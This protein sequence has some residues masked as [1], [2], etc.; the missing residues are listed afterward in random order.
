M[1]TT[2]AVKYSFNASFRKVMVEP[3]RTTKSR[4]KS[5]PSAPSNTR[6]GVEE[7]DL[8]Q[9][10]SL[11]ADKK[12]VRLLEI[13][14]GRELEPI[15][16]ELG[17]YDLDE[18]PEYIALSYMWDQG[19]G[20][21][22]IECQGSKIEVTENLWQFLRQYRARMMEKQDQEMNPSKPPRLW[23]D[24]ISINQ[25]DLKERS[26][27]VSLMRDIYTSAE[28]VIVW[29][30]L[31]KG[32]DE[33]AFLLT[34]YP[35]L[36]KVEEML[37]GLVSLL[38]KPYWSRVWVVQEV[39]LAR[40]ADMWCGGF[41]ADF[42]TVEAIWKREVGQ[43]SLSSTSSR[44]L[45]TLGYTLFQKRKAF[46]QSRIYKREI[47][48]RRNSK[49]LKA[50]F[51]LRDLLESFESSQ[52]S[53]P[54]DK[55]Y[56]FL[57]VASKGRGQAIQPDYSK[58]PLAL[59]V[60]VLENQC[61]NKHRKDEED[62]YKLLHLLRRT[63]GVTRTQLAKYLLQKSLNAQPH[64]YVLAASDFMVASISCISTIQDVGPF[65]DEAEAFTEGSWRTTWTR[66]TMH[67]RSLSNQDILDLGDLVAHPETSTV[68]SFTEPHVPGAPYPG[69][70][71]L[72]R[73][74][75]IAASTELVIQGLIQP[76]PMNSPTAADTLPLTNSITG[77]RNL[78]TM[79]TNSMLHASNLHT[80][81]RPT[82]TRR[83]TDHR[84]DRYATFVGTN[85]ITGLACISGASGSYQFAAGDRI[86]SFAG[87][88][89]SNNAFIVRAE[90]GG[91]WAISGFARILLPEKRGW[92]GGGGVEVD[93]EGEQ[94]MC[95]HCHLTDVLELQRCEVLNE[96]QM[97]RLLVNTLRGRQDDEV[98]RC[99][100]GPERCDVLEFG[101]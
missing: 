76:T 6:N 31:A 77:T 24:A 69:R 4:A 97:E 83:H 44:I 5:V 78:R 53:E 70:A 32:H 75:I 74:S 11:D 73:R 58:P 19:D 41:Q 51:R 42:S 90:G 12:T 37:A 43:N 29:L 46:R 55:I 23:I 33:L 84:Y 99:K 95:F 62:D 8:L 79:F 1:A 94:V 21:R 52:S 82:L 15:S 57:G 65:V 67:P 14:P 80:A 20:K 63:L 64:M 71:E 10:G 28:S 35:Q 60:D 2:D 98:H 9:Y 89:D 50:T 61:Y 101:L 40:R 100:P 26:H 3:F 7:V 96:V 85:G 30:G 81:A 16:A 18:K 39:V 27:Q 93:K 25:S 68:L 66:P 59:L 54:F 45:N 47:L 17:I 38:N 91:K 56:G 87:V 13:L 88:T 22:H 34:R 49:T 48:G 92:L 86:C 36:L 72:L